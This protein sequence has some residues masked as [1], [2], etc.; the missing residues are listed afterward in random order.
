MASSSSVDFLEIY[1]D[2]EKKT[3]EEK[4]PIE[5]K[6]ALRAL[7]E[8]DFSGDFFSRVDLL[9]FEGLFAASRLFGFKKSA[10]GDSESVIINYERVANAIAS[11]SYFMAQ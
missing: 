2:R 6:I 1:F 11:R 8:E 3:R 5:V 7:R 10:R 9:I 4:M